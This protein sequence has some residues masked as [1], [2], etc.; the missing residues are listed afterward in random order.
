MR[1]LFVTPCYKPY[2]GGVERVVEQLCQR[3]CM[4]SDVEVLGILTSYYRYPAEIMTGL[5]AQEQ[6]DGA[7]VFRLRFFPEK[8]PYFYH[9]DTGLFGHNMKKVIQSFQPTHIH[10]MVYD[11]FLPNLQ[12]YFL[13]QK[14]SAQI[15]TIFVHDFHL[16]IGTYP[17]L[18]FNRWLANHVDIVHVVSQYGKEVVKQYFHLSESRIVI[19]PLGS[20]VPKQPHQIENNHPVT[21]LSVGRLCA[22]K[23]QMNLV[24]CFLRIQ[25]RIQSACQLILVGDDGG[26][27]EKI[28]QVVNEHHLQDRVHLMGHISQDELEYWYTNSDIFAL[29]TKDESFGLVFTEAMAA[30]I[31]VITYAVG[32]LPKLLTNGAILLPPDNIGMVEESLVELINN[33]NK[34]QQLG[35]EAHS[36]AISHFSWNQTVEQ[37]IQV[38]RRISRKKSSH[39]GITI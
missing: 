23:G 9:L 4:D 24:C 39:Q 10:Y 15:M 28:Q 20:E 1:I 6:I 17:F 31:P 14:Y 16:S 35:Q 5:Q 36:F 13:S 30:G 21:I 33:K 2:L 3:L 34:R 8:M 26:D 25:D 19:I 29:L 22:K 38:Y 32:P 18:W 11:W 37:M 27:M 12:S 7:T